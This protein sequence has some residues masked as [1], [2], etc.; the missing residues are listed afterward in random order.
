[1][2][3]LLRV[4]CS[5]SSIK[6]GFA[7]LERFGDFGM[8]AQREAGGVEVRGH[9]ARFGLNLVADRRHGLHHARAGAIRAGLAQH[10]LERLLGALARDGHQAEFVEREHLRR[11]ASARSA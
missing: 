6:R 4:L 7:R 3:T 11:R 10:A 8:H 5:S 9:L 2:M 1:M